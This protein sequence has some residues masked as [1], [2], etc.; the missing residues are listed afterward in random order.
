MRNPGDRFKQNVL[1]AFDRLWYQLFTSPIHLDTALAQ[2]PKQF[3]V[4]A[5]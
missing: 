5:V 3:K 4:C 1:Q 2:Q